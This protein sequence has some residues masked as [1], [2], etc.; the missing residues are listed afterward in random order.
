MGIILPQLHIGTIKS[1]YKIQNPYEP[2]STM[3]AKGFER[4][5][6]VF[7]LYSCFFLS[8]GRSRNRTILPILP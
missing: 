2:I 5:S 4:R 8:L 7:Q 1:H 6:V 3:S